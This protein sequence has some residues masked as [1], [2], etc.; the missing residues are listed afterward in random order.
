[1]CE[2]SKSSNVSQRY[3]IR[4]FI[5][6]PLFDIYKYKENFVSKKVQRKK[7]H[8]DSWE[9]AHEGMLKHCVILSLEESICKRSTREV[10]WKK[11]MKMLLSG[12]VYSLCQ[13]L[14]YL[15]LAHQYRMRFLACFKAAS[16]EMHFEIPRT[17]WDRLYLLEKNKS[18]L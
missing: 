6:C 16:F 13:S 12:Y 4:Y 7:H 9:N 15:Y 18:V 11:V 8:D 1:M 10:T 17:Q 14:R 3:W 5:F 2:T